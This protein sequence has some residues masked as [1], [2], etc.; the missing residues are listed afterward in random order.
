[1]AQLNVVDDSVKSGDRIDMGTVTGPL[2]PE[3]EALFQE[4]ADSFRDRFV[5]RVAYRR[6]SLS[7]EDR[8]T[9]MD[10]RVIAAPQAVQMHLVDRLGYVQDA[11]EEAAGISGQSGPEVVVYHRAGSPARSLYDIAPAPPR[12]SDA[13]P[14][15]YPGLERNKLPGFL[16]LWQP[17]PTLPRTSSR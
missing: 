6:P 1:M 13:I 8:A 9:I 15:S 11:I 4:M 3:T 2:E 10:G 17:D 5:Q 7:P 12:L 14:F 16:Y